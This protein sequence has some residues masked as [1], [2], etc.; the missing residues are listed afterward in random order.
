MTSLVDGIA[1]AMTIAIMNY[2]LLG[3]EFTVDGYYLHSFEIWLAT[4]VVF[5]G[6]GNVGYTLLEYRLGEKEFVSALSAIN[7]V[8][9]SIV[10]VRRPYRKFCVATIL[11]SSNC[12]E[13]Q[14]IWV[15]LFISFFF[16]GGMSIHLSQAMLAHLFS[17]NMT[18]A[19][20]KKEVER[21]NFFKEVPR[22]LKRFWFALTVS[23]ILVAAMI[24]L[25]TSLVPIE[26][27]VQ[28]SGWAVIFPLA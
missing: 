8:N 12:G 17:Y 26:W 19:A 4:T 11:V 2:I 21:S 15:L 22:I 7:L 6:A 3:F 24:I 28:G 10:A 25:S 18:W 27:R 5:L 1:A 13:F 20:T 14:S 9:Y 16:F 23:V